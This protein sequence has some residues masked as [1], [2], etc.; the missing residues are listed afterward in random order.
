MLDHQKGMAIV[1]ESLQYWMSWGQ[2]G[3]KSMPVLAACRSLGLAR[4][5]TPGKNPTHLQTLALAASN[6]A[7]TRM[8][9]FILA[10]EK[11][12]AIA[13]EILLSRHAIASGYRI[14]QSAR[15]PFEYFGHE[16]WDEIRRDSAGL[17]WTVTQWLKRLLLN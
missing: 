9:G 2:L 6:A 10:D 5:V 7:L 4:G 8:N 3:G 15:R 1:G 17:T 16:Q 13:S 14:R 12:E 11:V